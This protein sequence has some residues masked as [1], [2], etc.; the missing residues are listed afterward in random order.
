[1]LQL[2]Q[3]LVTCCKDGIT[4]SLQAC[5]PIVSVFYFFFFQIVYF[6]HNVRILAVVVS[7]NCCRVCY[8]YQK[9]IQLRK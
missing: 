7:H 9:G 5:R 1:M 8:L 3:Q 2:L 6:C 4:Q